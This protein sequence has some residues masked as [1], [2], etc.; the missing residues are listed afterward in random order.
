[1]DKKTFLSLAPEYYMLALYIHL[2]Y[3]R[4]YYTDMSW[5]NDFT[6]HD[7]DS[8]EVY[9]YIHHAALRKEAVRLMLKHNALT[10]I[11]DP[12]GP[13]IWQRT[14]HTDLFADELERSPVSAFF[15]AKASGD[16]RSW[17]NAA[18]HKVNT[19]ADEFAITTRDFD[20]P[21]FGKSTELDA[22]DEWAPIAFDQADL[23]V[24]EAAKQLNAATTAIEQNN[25]Y[26]ETH[27]QERDAVV[28][29]LKGGLEKL[30]SGVISLAWLRRT[31]TA[32]RTASGRFA[33]SV[34]GQTIDGATLALKEFVK[35]HVSH[36]LE[37][38]SSFW[39]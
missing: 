15:K 31:A 29:D 4:D 22:L 39:P 26:S 2:Q 9:I 38:L 14:A 30:K 7:Q 1:M 19:A 20:A 11:P 28:Q 27:P 12:F 18:L 37:Y 21:D 6:Y 16:P 25:G 32:L 3:P 24:E 13:T 5:Q 8:D 17:I 10:V 35:T 36:A 23:V 33:N 34:T